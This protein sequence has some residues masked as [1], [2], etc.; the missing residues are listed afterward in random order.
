MIQS[1]LYIF[2]RFF[3]HFSVSGFLFVVE[4]CFTEARESKLFVHVLV[5]IIDLRSEFR[6]IDVEMSQRMRYRPDR[7]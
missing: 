4:A 3:L 2:N 6:Q 1:D 7:G 5:D